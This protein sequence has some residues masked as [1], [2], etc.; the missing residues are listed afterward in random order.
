MKV[1]LAQMNSQDDLEL[2]LSHAEKFI[3]EAANSEGADL[4]VFPEYFAFLHDD[5]AQMQATGEEL[6]GPIHAR[7]SAAAKRNRITVHAG[8]I[9]ER[10]GDK[11]Y[12]TT[13]VFGPQ[14]Q[15]L[16]R[17][18]KM[19]LFDIDSPNGVS[20]RESEMISRGSDVATYK[21]GDLTVGCAICYDIRFPELFRK[22]RDLGADLIVLPAAFTLN[23]GKDHWE[24]LLRARAIETQ[25]YFIAT[26]QAM[27]YADGRK[28][29]WGHSSVADPWGH[30]IAQASD[31]VGLV[32]ARI[33]P[34]YIAK[35]R[36]AIPVANHHVLA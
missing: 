12:N 29:N 1:A 25:T 34:A 23:T 4:V 2:N 14:G 19:H 10:R 16:A 17:Y 21:V 13:V 26:G 15:E 28:W 18:S 36:Q 5:P 35:V 9:V 32:T 22:L 24:V 8:S 20:Y 30:I 6:P 11:F 3:E 31:G 33:D 27:S 7:I